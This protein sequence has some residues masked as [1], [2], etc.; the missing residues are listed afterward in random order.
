MLADLQAVRP[1]WLVN[2]I[3]RPFT[4]LL[5]PIS[6]KMAGRPGF[7]MAGR[8]HHVGRRS[9]MDY[10]TPIGARIKN[11][12]VLIPLTFGNRSD[13]VRN[14]RIAGGA[15]LEVR[16]R[17][18]QMGP[19]EFLNWSEARRIV[20]TTYPVARITFKIL[21]IKQFMQASVLES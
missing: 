19:P 13:W 1:S 7:R 2:N 17:S 6:V 5:N 9:G 4:K 14:V 20:R 15:S 10:V 18:Y 8:I 12:Q 21:G 3:V 11:G 16:G